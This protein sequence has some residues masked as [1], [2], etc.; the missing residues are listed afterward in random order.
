M[1]IVTYGGGTN[2]TAMIIGMIQRNTPIDLILFADT[3]GER[4]DTYE[5]IDIFSNYCLS[6][7]YPNIKTLHYTDKNGNRLNLENELIK[8]HALPPITYGFKSCSEKFKTRVC[9]K[10]LNNNLPCKMVW[11]SDQKINK[12]VGFDAGETKRIECGKKYAE[13][14]KKYINHYPLYDWGWNR[15]KCIEV[16]RAEGLRLPGKSS[17]FFCPNMKR[18]EIQ[19][20][21]ETYP[22]LF[23]RAVAMEH[24]AAE[25]LTT[26][27]GLGRSWTWEA[28]KNYK[29]N[30][31]PQ[32]GIFDFPV[33]TMACGCAIPCGCFD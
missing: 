8:N 18:A 30:E 9:D 31:P 33:E 28:Y 17:C 2:S 19:S 12:F 14:D 24:N 6:K 23:D 11:K 26:L 22:E 7:G 16:I 27:K 3:G 10:Y 32:I 25:K 29:I 20:L 15:Q 1:N 13:T 5:F 21:W 4:P